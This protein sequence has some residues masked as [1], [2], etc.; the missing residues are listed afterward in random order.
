MEQS[1]KDLSLMEADFSSEFYLDLCPNIWS[2]YQTVFTCF[3]PWMRGYNFPQFLSNRWRAQKLRLFYRGKLCCLSLKQALSYQGTF[4]LGEILELMSG[5]SC[6]PKICGCR[7]HRYRLHQFEISKGLGIFIFLD[8]IT[9]DL[10]HTLL[11][12]Q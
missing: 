9:G 2:Q 5:F 3:H 7:P 8:L 4:L 6:Q 12:Q 11:Y 1:L 10:P